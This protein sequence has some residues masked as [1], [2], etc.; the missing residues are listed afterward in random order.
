LGYLGNRVYREDAMKGIT[1][2]FNFV[3]LM[4]PTV[5]L[6]GLAAATL[7]DASSEPLSL[8]ILPHAQN[9]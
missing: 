7:A 1:E 3:A 8:P 9:G 6:I 5:I 4:L 2:Y